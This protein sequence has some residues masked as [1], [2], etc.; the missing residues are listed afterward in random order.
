MDEKLPPIQRI[1]LAA[2]IIQI[3]EGVKKVNSTSCRIPGPE[4][5]NWIQR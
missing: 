1:I 2:M 4:K 5:R 3:I